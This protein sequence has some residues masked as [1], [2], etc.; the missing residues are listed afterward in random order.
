[1]TDET[2]TEETA[3]EEP[4]KAAPKATATAKRAEA[5]AERDS[6]GRLPASASL[7]ATFLKLSGFKEADI[8]GSNE[9]S[10]AFVTSTGGKYAVSKS[11]KS[12]RTL[13]GP[14]T[15]NEKKAAEEEG[16]EEE[17]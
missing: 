8:L 10:R 12:L 14:P 4:V 6:A 3:E 17:E 15:P 13:S 1:M 9:D 2:T 7:K 16:E 11:G 5:P